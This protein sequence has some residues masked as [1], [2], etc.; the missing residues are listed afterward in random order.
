MQDLLPAAMA[1][2]RRVEQVF[3]ATCDAW[4][5]GEI[6]T[7]VIEHLHLFTSSGTLSPHMLGGVYSFLDW[8]GWSGERV[9][10]RPDATIPVARLYREYFKGQLGKFYYVEDMFRFSNQGERRE[11]WQCG[12]EL[13]GDTWPLGDVEV[14]TI[15]RD[16]LLRLGV[17][18]PR[19]RLSHTGILRAILATTGYSPE[20]Q[21]SLYDR[22]LD[23]DPGV[24]N[25]IEERLPQLGAPLRLLFDGVGG[26]S[27]YLDNL[28]S[29]FA[30][31]VPALRRP[32]DDLR[33]VASTLQA[34][35]CDYELDLMIVRDFEYYTGPV[36]HLSVDGSDVASGGRYDNLVLAHDGSALPACGFGVDIER[37]AAL[38]PAT[39]PAGTPEAVQVRPATLDPDDLAL[40]LMVVSELQADRLRAELIAPDDEPAC[41]WRLTVDRHSGGARYQLLDCSRDNTIVAGSMEQI[42]A[43]LSRGRGT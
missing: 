22:I 11:I 9:V 24:L 7:P 34:A 31:S 41:R 3:C 32:L 39:A 42:L 2:F 6:R 30:A 17:S 43:E 8:D 37:V 29:A 14:I 1:R 21:L 15:A 10:L 13:I 27:G 25:S 28:Q 5:F 23:G 20:E 33:L 18:N 36:F 40:A 16:V 19:V 38:L 4:G 35:G 26:Q 12:V